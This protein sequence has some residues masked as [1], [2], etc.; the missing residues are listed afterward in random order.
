MRHGK[1]KII[2]N[3]KCET[4]RCSSIVNM[5]N[6]LDHINGDNFKSS[7]AKHTFIKTMSENS[8]TDDWFN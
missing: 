7:I 1:I 6:L 8:N 3:L 4:T 5:Y 2:Q